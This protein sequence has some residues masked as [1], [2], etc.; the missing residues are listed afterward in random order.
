MIYPRGKE[1]LESALDF[2]EKVLDWPTDKLNESAEHVFKRLKEKFYKERD[3]R[4]P[5]VENKVYFALKDPI[6]GFFKKHYEFE[7]RGTI[8]KEGKRVLMAT[9]QYATDQFA[10]VNAVD[11]RISFLYTVDNPAKGV[12]SA[13]MPFVGGIRVY[14]DGLKREK[15]RKRDL[16]LG[17]IPGISR[18]WA[19][20]AFMSLPK[21]SEHIRDLLAHTR[22]RLNRNE[23]L[24]VFPQGAYH[25]G[26]L[27]KS[28][29]GM[30]SILKHYEKRTGERVSIIPVG[31][32]YVFKGEKTMSSFPLFTLPPE[33]TKIIVTFGEQIYIGGGAASEV[34]KAV[35][36]KCGSL[37]NIPYELKPA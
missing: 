7:V 1:S 26:Y 16:V 37:S 29:D 27:G 19:N 5:D 35:M 13:L 12:L 14:A 17:R 8:P 18:I 6:I 28:E 15:P 3:K 23:L 10:L 34:I 2:P 20:Y 21:R 33:G 4:R 22:E 25:T 32:E 9:H 30:I 11:E 31:I 36:N 24:G